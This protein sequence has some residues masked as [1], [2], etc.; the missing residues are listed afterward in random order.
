MGRHRLRWLE[1]IE[2][3]VREMKVKR[4]PH[5]AVDR[6]EGAS[7]IREVKA[8]RGAQIQGVSA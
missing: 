6:E 8:V 7:V 4:W 5:K 2:K 1:N 3:D